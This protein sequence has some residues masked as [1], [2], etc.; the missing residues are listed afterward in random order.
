M[1]RMVLFHMCASGG[2]YDCVLPLNIRMFY[3]MLISNVVSTS[4]YRLLRSVC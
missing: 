2:P 3:L 4:K 1:L